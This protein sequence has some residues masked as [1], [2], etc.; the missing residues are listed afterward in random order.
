MFSGF[1]CKK[2]NIIPLIRPNIL[3]NKNI[4]FTVKCKCNTKFLTYD[5]L[6]HNYYSKNIEQKN[7]INAKIF[8]EIKEN[9]EPILQ[10]IDE[11]LRT[12][13]YNNDKLIRF[14]NKFIDYMNSFINEINNSIN[15]LMNINENIEKTSLIFMNSYKDIST[16]YSNIANIHFILDNKI[17]KINEKDINT[18]FIE[19]N[20]KKTIDNI[21]NY[22]DEYPLINQQLKYFSEVQEVLDDFIDIIFLSNELLLIQGEK[23]LY[24]FSIKDLKIIGKIKSDSIINISKT[25]KNNILCLFPDCIKIYP[26]FTYK[27]INSL[28]NKNKKED[29]NEYYDENLLDIKPLMIFNLHIKYNKILYWKDDNHEINKNKFLL[30]NDNM[31]GFFECDL[32]KKSCIKYHSYHLNDLFKIELIKYENNNALIL[33]TPSNLYLFNLSSFNIIKTFEMEFRK[34]NKATIM[35][36]NDNE[37]LV[38]IDRYIYVLNLEYCKIKLKIIFETRITYAFLLNDKSIIIC[39]ITYAK[40]FSP[41]TFQVMSNFYIC[42]EDMQDYDFDYDYDEPNI[43]LF[44]SISKCI[45]LSNSI[46]L[47]LLTNGKCELN[48][49]II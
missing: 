45:E 3:D 44:N 20:F 16:N 24:F 9:K 1:Y 21:K 18:L 27:H 12:I 19:N 26:E 36:I 17:N 47:L 6:Y 37:L 48:K 8:K 7:I 28:K 43:R 30:Y 15:N 35:Q 4:N 29:D 40:K 32:F 38:T 33:F 22:I 46:F 39:G 25:K 42:R 2:C 41:K 10:K 34:D 23:Y 11:T 31:I 49:L 13:R 5:K 14:K